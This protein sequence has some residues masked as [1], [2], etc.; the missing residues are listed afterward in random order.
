[1]VE[2]IQERGEMQHQKDLLILNKTKSLFKG[3]MIFEP[4]SEK[5]N[6]LWHFLL[7]LQITVNIDAQFY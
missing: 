1:M 2:V 5:K 3:L 6:Q 7:Y 4:I